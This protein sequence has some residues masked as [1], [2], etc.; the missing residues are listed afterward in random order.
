MNDSQTLNQWAAQYRHFADVECPQDPLYVAICR[1]VADSPELLALM[2]EAPA[3]QRRPNLLLAALH[4]L[5]LGGAD[6]GLAAYY[7]SADGTRLPDAEL[8]ARLLDFVRRQRSAL[9]ANLRSRSTQTNE[10][11]RCAVLWP[12]LQY[13]SALSGRQDLALLDFGC[14]AGLNLGVDAYR[15]DY[16]GF[17][18]GAPAAAERPTIHCQWLGDSVPPPK[19]W[20]L[21]SRL[22]LDP[23]PIDVQDEAAVRWLRA[24]L[25]PHDRERARRLDQALALARAADHPL[26]PAEDCLAEIE[27]WLD[28]LPARVQPLL[29]NSWVLSYFETGALARHRAEVERLLRERGLIWLSAEAAALRPPGLALP[30]VCGASDTLW[31]LQWA[32]EAGVLCQAALACSHPHGRWL[33]WLAPPIRG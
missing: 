25:W 14:S 20:R 3:T 18:L 12:A 22:G 31:T 4:E 6:D 27:P 8:P 2:A 9:V 21:H 15:Y 16:G 29:F 10:I 19:P 7:P 5:V 11:G 23:A 24:C 33:R 13:I 17:A 32:D 28:G 26:S 1:S 30:A